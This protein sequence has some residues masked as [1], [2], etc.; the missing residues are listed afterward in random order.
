MVCFSAI[1]VLFSL[2]LEKPSYDIIIK[3]M[4]LM[5]SSGYLKRQNKTLKVDILVKLLCL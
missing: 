4:R 5:S 3:S 1:F 2:L